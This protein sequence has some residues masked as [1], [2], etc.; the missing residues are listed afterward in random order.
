MSGFNTI[1]KSRKR[2]HEIE[3]K[4]N[5][6][7]RELEKTKDIHEIA[8]T[9]ST[10]GIYVGSEDQVNQDH[11][12]FEGTSQG[13]QGIGL[14]GADGN[15][16][17]NASFGVVSGLSG[18][19][20]AP[21]HPTTGVRRSAIHI[22]SGLGDSTPLRPG[23]TTT[24]GFSDNPPTRTMGSALWFYDPDYNSGEGIWYNLEYG[25]EQ[26]AW[27]FWDTV[28][29]GQFAGL[30]IFNTDLDEHP[31][32]DIS[33]LISGLNFPGAN[34]AIGPAF[35]TV[36][37]QDRLDDPNFIPINID[38]LSDTG[39]EYLKEK[40]KKEKAKKEEDPYA[41]AR[42]AYFK[43]GGQMAFNYLSAKEKEYWKNKAS[44]GDSTLEDPSSED[45]SASEAPTPSTS[46]APTPPKSEREPIGFTPT[47][48]ILT[49]WMSRTDFMKMFPDSTMSDYLD[50]L[51]YGSTDFMTP[52]PDFP[53][54]WDLDRKAYE[55]FFMKGDLSGLGNKSGKPK[56]RH[57][58]TPESDPDIDQQ[59]TELLDK[60]QSELNNLKGKN[61]ATKI[62]GALTFLKNAIG[63]TNP[64]AKFIT[65][66]PVGD[67]G[68]E[69]LTSMV[70][71]Q[72]IYQGD[73]DVPLKD[74]MSY[75]KGIPPTFFN[76]QSLSSTNI[77]SS[78]TE[79]PYSDANFYQDP[80]T[81]KI[82][83]HTAETRKLYPDN[84]STFSDKNVLDLFGVTNPIAVRGNMHTQIVEP[85]GGEPYI[86]VHDFAYLNKAKINDRGELQTGVQSK[87]AQ[88]ISPL[89]DKFHGRKEGSQNHGGMTGY[90][91]NINGVSEMEFKVPYSQWTDKQ[92]EAYNK[93]R[94]KNESYI[95]EST[96]LGHFEPEILNVDIKQLR[97]KIKPE[98][99]KDPPP[100][101]ID[102][103]SKKSRLAPKE[104]PKDSFIKI[105]KKDLAK[106]HKLK[107]SEIKEFMD[108]FKMIND[109][110]KRHPEELIYA[111]QRYPVGDKRLALLNWKMDQMLDASKE[112]VDKQFPE[113][114]NLF[115]K[116]KNK[117]KNTID[118]TDPKNFK[119]VKDP[120]KYVDVKKTKKL[121][122]TVTR[123]FNKPVKSKS[124]FGLNMGKVKKTNQK[125]IEKREQEQRVKEEER[126]YIQEKMEN[127]KSNW[128][129]SF[130]N[131]TVG[132]KVGQTFVH[133]PSGQTVTTAG[134]LGGVETVSSTV[135]IFGDEIPGPDASQYGLQGYA[136]PMNIMKRKDPEDTNK[137]LDAS[138]EFAKKVNADVMMNARVDDPVDSALLSDL[139]YK[140]TEDILAEVGDQWTY[141]EYMAMLDAIADKAAAK[142]DPIVKK[143]LEYSPT[144]KTPGDV[145]MSL[146]DA[147]TAITDARNKAEQALHD[148]WERYNKIPD[149]GGYGGGQGNPTN[150]R[151]SGFDTQGALDDSGYGMDPSR[152]TE[153]EARP[154]KE[155]EFR[156]ARVNRRGTAEISDK[157]KRINK[158]AETFIRYLTNQLPE[159]KW[160][161]YIGKDYV[162][163]AFESG[164][165]N[166]KGGVTVGDN[167]I[168]SASSLTF[169]RKS[170]RYRMNFKG[171]GVDDNFTQFSK[172]DYNIWQKAALNALGKYSADLQPAGLPSWLAPVQ[173]A[174]GAGASK[175]YEFS[176]LFGGGKDVDAFIE[177]DADKLQ[178][179]NPSL[180]QQSGLVW[181]QSMMGT[182]KGS[183]PEVT[184]NYY[185]VYGKLPPRA[186]IAGSTPYNYGDYPEYDPKVIEKIDS[187][188]RSSKSKTQTK[189]PSKAMNRIKSMAKTRR[190]SLSLDEPI[191]KRKN[192]K[193]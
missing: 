60:Q 13:G 173:T 80:S 157:Q 40:A 94:Q 50:A 6:L 92:K 125:M 34:G 29:S 57:E 135:S 168:G 163:H 162:R 187:M 22:T 122:E 156:K 77:P 164:Y 75:V 183:D 129:E 5:V 111:Q 1:K 152:D 3:E 35:N 61:V 42:A 106:N 95:P 32:G 100:E 10:S 86:K 24:I 127:K 82:K 73:N 174:I 123:H 96:K 193:N 109:F 98:F 26:A 143:I 155:D 66:I 76:D 153:T 139:G 88:F 46:E 132:M 120:I 136:K 140:S 19:A 190:Q 15:T 53:G 137:K 74:K 48:G 110:I 31:A 28:K 172:G 146:I 151:G 38:G 176:K 113:N 179:L 20:L 159:G 56:P 84:T 188:R 8:P 150:R 36:I 119:Q 83:A 33:G 116:I 67:Y 138:Q 169:D 165:F 104:L 78:S 2:S 72:P 27:G 158:A 141:E 49:K 90:P 45:D 63:A 69:I 93:S 62:D 68:G 147:Q 115:N 144:G 55:N 4:L 47:E 117:I 184:H 181:N 182:P 166:N 89:M 14:S 128:K 102:G 148:A 118:Q 81:G 112:Y 145:P 170:G 149:I 41:G 25:V 52:N 23:Q 37:T 54:A 154:E 18:V 108:T 114:Q 30:Y 70:L 79:Q 9:M 21:P 91:P 175:V 192:K 185:A 44:K 167:V 43:A 121:K 16:A 126:T 87:I 189:E 160:N 124:I 103:H 51:P 142:E 161:D 64:I 12:D 85:E 180:V 7:N 101:I 171:L 11:S 105:T 133:N 97:K 177:I 178:K 186:V 191:V 99:P 65:S 71:N 131:V 17:G 134:A 130:T 107:D 58:R 59:K 39:Y